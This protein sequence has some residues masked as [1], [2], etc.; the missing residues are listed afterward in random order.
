MDTFKTL[1]SSEI[2]NY[3]QRCNGSP[4][5]NPRKMSSI[6][7]DEFIDQLKEL[8]KNNSIDLFTYLK[9]ISYIFRY[10]KLENKL[11]ENKEHLLQQKLR[12]DQTL[13][14]LTHQILL[15]HIQGKDYNFIK[16]YI[17]RHRQLFIVKV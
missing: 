12:Y 15:A 17:I 11:I 6:Q 5:E 3:I 8:L 13:Q 2:V 9:H 1:E 14:G 7:R 16:N 4:P 10:E